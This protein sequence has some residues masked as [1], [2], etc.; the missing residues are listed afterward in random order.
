[1]FDI[2][3]SNHR[4]QC[5]FSWGNLPDDLVQYILQI[6]ASNIIQTAFRKSLLHRMH[7][8]RTLTI[9]RG[10]MHFH[11]RYRYR[12]ELDDVDSTSAEKKK[13]RLCFFPGVYTCSHA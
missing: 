10:H 12:D 9:S 1:M 3:F 4:S 7:I 11:N 5:T 2:F 8:V 6:H 13:I